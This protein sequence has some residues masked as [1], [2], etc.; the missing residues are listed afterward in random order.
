MQHVVYR[1]IVIKYVL[2]GTVTRSS[3]NNLLALLEVAVVSCV[4]SLLVGPSL[5]IL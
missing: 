3:P 1:Y 4:I 5:Y 2:V